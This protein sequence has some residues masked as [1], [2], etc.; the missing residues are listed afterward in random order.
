[1]KDHILRRIYIS[2]L[3]IFGVLTV[4][5]VAAMRS[6]NRAQASVDWVNHTYATIYEL[7][8]TLS[9]VYAGDGAIRTYAVTGDSRDLADAR[10][11]FANM[12]DHLQTAKALLRDNPDATERLA[13]IEEL[14]TRREALARKLW[15]AK[16]ARQEGEIKQLLQ[17]D[18][19]TTDL[20]E[21]RRGLGKLRGEQMELIGARDHQSYLQM[22]TTRWVVGAGVVI[23]LILFA[24]VAWLIKDDLT[25]RDRLQKALQLANEQLEAKVAERTRELTVANGHL[26]IE[27]LERQWTAQSLEHQL[28]YNTQIVNSVSDLVFVMTK[29]LH[30]TRIN[31]AVTHCTGLEEKELLGKAFDSVVEL[32][33]PGEGPSWHSI[34]QALKEGRDLYEQPAELRDHRGGKVP[35]RF[36]L[37]PLRD[38]N[39]VVGAVAILRPISPISVSS[40][41]VA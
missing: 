8:N 28:R 40:A 14:A 10:E 17:T 11:A 41:P 2:F 18:D 32:P 27:N 21:I 3:V 1:M 34:L 36:N 23:D 16:N 19:G 6:I 29:V 22:Q 9:S 33:A 7:E 5:A 25:A 30:L 20:A 26:T 31:P 15:T 4:I 13:R 37:F 38:G 24:A 39:K 12:S 35:A